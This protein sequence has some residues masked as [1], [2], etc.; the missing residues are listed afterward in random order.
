MANNN[1]YV[2]LLAS[3]GSIDLGSSQPFFFP[4]KVMMSLVS[5]RG[6]SGQRRR[7]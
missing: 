4:V 3:Q 6:E 5:K 7:M 1:G 2:N